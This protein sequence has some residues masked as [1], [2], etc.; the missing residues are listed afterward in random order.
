MKTKLL[1]IILNKLYEIDPSLSIKLIND[2]PDTIIGFK[3]IRSINN[4]GT[5]SIVSGWDK[6]VD[7][8]L[9]FSFDGENLYYTVELLI[10]DCIIDEFL[11]FLESDGIA[12]IKKMKKFEL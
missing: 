11:S 9:E 7:Y 12:P 5:L 2:G 3:L 1:K 8:Q 6:Y 10:K 4:E